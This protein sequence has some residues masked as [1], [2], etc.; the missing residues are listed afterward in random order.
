MSS[1]KTTLVGILA[2]VAIMAT[3]IGAMLDNDPATTFS[4][5]AI[6]S[7][8]AALGIGLFARDNT[9]TSEQAGLK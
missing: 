1:W 2:A 9:V 4:L 7:A 6:F 8:L 3:Q 5:E